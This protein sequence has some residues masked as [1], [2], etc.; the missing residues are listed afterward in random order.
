MQRYA[1]AIENGIDWQE[2]FPGAA[3]VEISTE[4]NGPTMS[5]RITN[6]EGIPTQYVPLG[7][8]GAMIIATKRVNELGFYNLGA[9]QVGE[10]S[11]TINK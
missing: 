2:I 5:L 3:A 8:P 1:Q 10:K 9:T 7:T 4:G 6:K 11:R